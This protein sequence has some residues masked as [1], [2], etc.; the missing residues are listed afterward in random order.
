MM[1]KR[2]R[3]VVTLKIAIMLA[4]IPCVSFAEATTQGGQSLEQAASDPT[5]SLMNIQIQNVY[6]G[7]YHNLEF[8]GPEFRGHL[9]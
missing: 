2:H 1:M 6:T 9:T 5:A 7:D 4:L 8:R 3:W